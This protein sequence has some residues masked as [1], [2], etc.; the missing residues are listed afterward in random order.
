MQVELISKEDLKVFKNELLQE[1]KQLM[2]PARAIQT[3]AKKQR[4]A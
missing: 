1:I 3:M 4:G 2:Q